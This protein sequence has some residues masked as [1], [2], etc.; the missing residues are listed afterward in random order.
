MALFTVCAMGQD[1]ELEPLGYLTLNRSTQNG[2][3]IE[4]TGDYEYHIVSLNGDPYIQTSRLP[5]DLTDEEIWVAMEY[6]SPQTI[7]N[8]EFFFSPIAAGREQVFAF[9]L[10]EE[11]T[12]KYVNIAASRQNFG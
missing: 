9:T 3:S 1:G 5:R 12:A 6:K 10:T 11:W 7:N 8:A 2:M 4:E